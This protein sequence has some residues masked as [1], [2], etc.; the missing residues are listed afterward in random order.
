[1]RAI[2]FDVSASRFLLARTLGGATESVLFGPLS[3]LRL[4]D[5]VAPEL[6]GPDWVG[7]RVIACGI[8]GSD[9]G[10]LTYRSSPAMEPFGS[11]PAVLGHEVLAVVESVGE[12]VRDLAPGQRVTVDPMIS[13]TT[14]GY[15][16]DDPCPSCASG[17]HSTCES[18]PRSDRLW[19]WI[20]S[21]SKRRCRAVM[22]TM[23]T[24]GTLT[25][26]TGFVS[27]A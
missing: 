7:L 18:A 8:C 23:P 9:V 4:A 16:S 27:K 1:M 2:T 12:N 22:A 10:N 19:P 21:C 6:P 14:R 13:C 20:R 25:R 26:P 17:L 24:C 3:G 15:A 11:F 5:P